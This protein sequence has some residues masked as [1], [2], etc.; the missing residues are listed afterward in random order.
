[1]HYECNICMKT[2][3]QLSNLKVRVGELIIIDYLYFC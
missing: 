2:F 3:G 1:M